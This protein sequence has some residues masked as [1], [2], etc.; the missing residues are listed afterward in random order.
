MSPRP[1]LR[2]ICREKG[3]WAL[4]AASAVYFFQPLF[5]SQV[6]YLR[7]LHFLF[8]HQR[9]LWADLLRAGELPLWDPYHH[10]GMPFL[11]DVSN[12]FFYPSNLLHFVFSPY[13]AVTLA[14]V[15]HVIGAAVA[16][17]ALAR[18]LGL[19][20][21][22][23]FVAG[24][25]Y[26]YCGHNLSQANTL[27]RLLALPYL[28]LMLLFWQ[29][30][31]DEHRRRWLAAAAICGALQIF[32]GAPTVIA[33]SF[34]TV[35]GWVLL[36]PGRRRRLGLSAWWL[37]AVVAL[38]AVQLLPLFEMT[39]VSA[40]GE[41]YT[42][43]DFAGWSLEPRQLPELVVPGFTGRVG[44]HDWSG[45][46][47]ARLV[48][49][50][51]PYVL[52]I[53]LG[54]GALAL[55]VLGGFATALGRRRRLYLAALAVLALLLALGRF[56]PLL[57]LLY[58]LPGA[59]LFRFPVKFLFLATLPV[60]LLAA[61][62]LEA[63]R[64][65]AGPGV[66]AVAWAAGFAGLAI[67]VSFS[68]GAERFEAFFFE[69]S[70]PGVTAGLTAAFGH[71]AGVFLLA[72]CVVELAR[73]RGFDASWAIAG[74]V[75]LDLT[76]A[77]RAVNPTAPRELLERE[78]PVVAELAHVLAGGQPPGGR[79]YRPDRPLSAIPAPPSDDVV[80]RHVW[81]GQSL[82]GYQAAVYRLPAVYFPDYHGLTPGAMARLNRV[83]AGL[84]WE[85]RLP[86]LRM[87]AVRA[88][89]TEEELDLPGLERVATFANLSSLPVH[90]YRLE[91]TAERAAVVTHWRT[92]AT[93]ADA[94]RDVLYPDFD[95]R[96]HAVVEGELPI[97]AQAGCPG[98]ARVDVEVVS[99]RHRVYRVTT[100]CPSLL[101]LSETHYPGWRVGVD[102]ARTS[103]LRANYA[104]SAVF[105]EPGEHRVDWRFV[106]GSVIWGAAVSVVAALA[107]MGWT[108]KEGRHG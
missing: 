87:A 66:R 36:E 85:R 43:A 39:A 49:S 27:L 71:A 60:A 97:P 102:G 98:D 79:L 96:R 15:V 53:Y 80:W 9:A 30:F 5:T 56:F 55:A 44:G 19:G 42:F 108:I 76:F 86:L 101:V 3:L 104:F 13:Q 93:P 7:D 82:A 25:V 103:L 6:F 107:L 95:P 75:L 29:R 61:A 28:P 72:A 58:E 62:G 16:A 69:T 17:Y 105:L 22:A 57:E 83:V 59:S 88:V 4:A 81:Y 35:L 67:W 40:R 37:A 90:L 10:A 74:I 77:G 14:A 34:A 68:S 78:P 94:L 99:H 64:A 2:E 52:S 48:D 46:W 31:L 54:A 91:P 89:V 20:A 18:R 21:P 70:G 24:A 73:R 12:T 47:G 84:P 50:G 41:G 26:A 92:A 65:G 45:Y 32:A 51:S 1:R 38:A 63:L 100:R 11:G 23:A 106:P 8:A 33:L